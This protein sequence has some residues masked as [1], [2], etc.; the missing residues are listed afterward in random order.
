MSEDRRQRRRA[1]QPALDLIEEAVRLLREAPLAAGVSYYVGSVPF[2]LGLLYFIAD[3]GRNAYAATRLTEAS[4]V[5]ALLYVWRKCWQ[6]VFASQLRATLLATPDTQWTIR[7]IG[8]LVLLQAALQPW[9]LIL[10]PLAFAITVPFVWVSSF[11]QNVTVLGDGAATR[12]SPV[13]QAISQAKHWPVQAHLAVSI[14]AVFIFFIWLNICVALVLGPQL[15]KSFLN[16]ET[17]FT[18]SIDAYLNTTFVATTFALT[19]LCFDPLWKAVYVLRCFQGAAVSTG[20]DLILQLKRVRVP[21]RRSASLVAAVLLLLAGLSIEVLAAEPRAVAVQPAELNERIDRVLERREYAWRAP[22]QK[23]EGQRGW[24]GTWVNEAAKTVMRWGREGVA[25]VKR[26]FKWV[27]ERWFPKR[28]ERDAT[29]AFDWAAA[30]HW[31]LWVSV[32]ALGGLLVW[33]AL[34]ALRSRRVETVATVLPAMPDLRAEDVA[35]DALPEAQWLELAREH[36]N[37][38]DLQL[39]LRAAWL[40]CL[41]HLGHR[42]LLRIARY[43]SNFDYDRELRRRARARAELL[44]AFGENLTA[45]ERAWYGRHAVTPESFANFT[46]NLERI[47]AC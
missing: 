47:R 15:L 38:G 21:D 7:R 43:K 5:M 14:L 40:A 37:R 33:S 39:A 12:G 46:G 17:V 23:I 20:E 13:K 9:S 18:R 25:S 44:A 36:A 42:E 8:R 34:R 24:I 10:R 6:T 30:A 45:F 27:Y 22:R 41:A 19:S 4:L 35:P 29:G 3:M 2:W 32:A 1:G 31:L 26:F 11:F 28:P 16:V